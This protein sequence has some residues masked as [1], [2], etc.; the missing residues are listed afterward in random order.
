MSEFYP[1]AEDWVGEPQIQKPVPV[2]AQPVYDSKADEQ[3]QPMAE[4]PPPLPPQPVY[5]E[6]E[7]A[8][9]PAPQN[10]AMEPPKQSRGC[11]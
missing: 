4:E 1:D 2:G 8:A 9:P 6:A 3:Q 7:P 10:D 5:P 11:C